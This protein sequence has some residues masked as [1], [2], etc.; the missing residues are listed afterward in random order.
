MLD[1]M[2]NHTCSARVLPTDSDNPTDLA[3]HPS[4]DISLGFGPADISADYARANLVDH[5]PNVPRVSHGICLGCHKNNVF[6]PA[7]LQFTTF[8]ASGTK[9]D[10]FKSPTHMSKPARHVIKLP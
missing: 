4:I 10:S 1:A 5:G 8:P 2:E 9:R 7:S 6:E 3:G